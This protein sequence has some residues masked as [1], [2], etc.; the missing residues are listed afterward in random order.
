MVPASRRSIVR[1]RRIVGNSDSFSLAPR[2]RRMPVAGV[3]ADAPASSPTIRLSS[4]P[5][6][7]R[8]RAY[9][10]PSFGQ[11]S[12][13]FRLAP[14]DGRVARFWLVVPYCQM[15]HRLLPQWVT[16]IGSLLHGYQNLAG[17]RPM[18]TQVSSHYSHA[19]KQGRYSRLLLTLT[20]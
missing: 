10:L 12:T 3:I 4:L 7:T 8:E 18:A 11:T 19:L 16:H 5:L 6:S 15:V 9:L 20:R 17:A 2:C 14:F 13:G 1:R